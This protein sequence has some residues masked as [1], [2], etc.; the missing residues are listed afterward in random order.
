MALIST[1]VIS[2]GILTRIL[3]ND[4]RSWAIV[5]CAALSHRPIF[6]KKSRLKLTDIWATNGRKSKESH[7]ATN[8][9]QIFQW[10][11]GCSL[12]CSFYSKRRTIASFVI[13]ALIAT[14]YWGVDLFRF[15]SKSTPQSRARFLLQLYA[16]SVICTYGLYPHAQTLEYA[17]KPYYVRIGFL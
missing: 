9:L 11:I 3:K 6:P 17:R 4:L 8:K 12:I 13:S 2:F 10:D 5:A 1:H 15:W 7:I 14:R 16:P